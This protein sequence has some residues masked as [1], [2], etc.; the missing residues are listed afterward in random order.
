MS[1]PLIMLLLINSVSYPFVQLPYTNFNTEYCRLSGCAQNGSVV[2]N[3][4]GA[5]V[6][7]SM[8]SSNVSELNA[9]LFTSYGC[10]IDTDSCVVASAFAWTRPRP[11]LMGLLVVLVAGINLMRL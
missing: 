4:S 5:P 9:S 3:A 10:T 1:N 11:L 7:S 8:P 2:V 6:T